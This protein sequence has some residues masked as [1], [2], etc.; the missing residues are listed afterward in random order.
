MSQDLTISD[1]DTYAGANIWV[2][3]GDT[4]TAINLKS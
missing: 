4:V 1:H 3:K 2:L